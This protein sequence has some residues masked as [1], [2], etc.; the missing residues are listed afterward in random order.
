MNCSKIVARRGLISR[1]LLLYP[2]NICNRK[3]SAGENR[4]RGKTAK[5]V[6][7][8]ATSVQIDATF[9]QLLVQ[10]VQFR[11]H[12]VQN[13]DWKLETRNWKADSSTGEYSKSG[14]S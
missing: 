8:V 7:L 5:F 4:R 13:R 6:Q 1:F 3:V 14:V 9:V 2:A 12:I 10:P 11:V